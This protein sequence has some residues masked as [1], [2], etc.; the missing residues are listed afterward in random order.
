VNNHNPSQKSHMF[1]GTQEL[2]PF[3]RGDLIP[4]K[5][6]CRQGIKS[7]YSLIPLFFPLIHA[8]YMRFPLSQN[9]HAYIDTN[10]LFLS[11]STDPVNKCPKDIG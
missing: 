1:E 3:I 2:Y 8:F 11:N 10:N 4:C 5:I 7:S 9:F 6:E